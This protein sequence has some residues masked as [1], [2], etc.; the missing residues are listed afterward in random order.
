MTRLLS[1]RA[2]R[3][4]P[5]N[6]RPPPVIISVLS[7][8]MD[9]LICGGLLATMLAMHRH[10]SRALVLGAW[11]VMLIATIWLMAHHV[12]GSLALKLSY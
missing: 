5:V 4:R 9:T 6:I 11:W 7:G 12:T 3:A 1:S 10:T 2:P 8:I